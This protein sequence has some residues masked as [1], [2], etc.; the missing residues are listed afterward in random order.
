MKKIKRLGTFAL[1]L[2]LLGCA[3]PASASAANPEEGLISIEVIS[4]EEADASLPE[5]ILE[6]FE[7]DANDSSG[8]ASTYSIKIPSKDD[9]WNLKTSGQYKF[10]VNTQMETIY[11][12]YVFSGH[13]GSVKV[14][15]DETTSSSGNYKFKL[16]K[17]GLIN[18]TIYTYKFAHGVEQTITM[19]DFDSDDLIYFAIVP[20]AHTI[21]SSDSYI[22]RN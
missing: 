17:R 8:N 7:K 1:S 18:T 15:L 3:L 6:T 13:G 19:N 10:H 11:S 14:H 22:K 5:Y 9:K 16:C 20:N 12:A 21:L 2:I 4:N